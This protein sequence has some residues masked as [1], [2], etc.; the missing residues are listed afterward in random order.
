LTFPA[1][2]PEHLDRRVADRHAVVGIAARVTWRGS[3]GS[4]DLRLPANLLNISRRGAALKTLF[5]PPKEVP[6]WISI[7]QLPNEWVRCSLLAAERVSRTI[8][9]WRLEFAEECPPGILD[10]AREDAEIGFEMAD[11]EPIDWSIP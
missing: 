9:L 8:F 4:A 6:L 7:E 3:W 1:W 11:D 10:I 2:L 5:P